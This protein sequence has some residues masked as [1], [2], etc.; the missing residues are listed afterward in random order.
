MKIIK[1]IYP[2]IVLRAVLL[3]LTFILLIPQLA[4]SQSDNNPLIPGDKNFYEIQKAFNDNWN[5]QENKNDMKG[6]KQYKRWE[7]FME[8]RVYPSGILPDPM[9]TYNALNPALPIRPDHNRSNGNWTSM[10]P[11]ISS[12]TG[13]GRINCVV[14]H[15]TDTNIIW[16][17]APSGGLWKSTDGGASWHT[18]TDNL[19]AIGIS[20]LVIHP[21]NPDT[22]YLASSD[23]DAYD[24]Y[25]L[26][27]LKS[28]D[29]GSTWNTTGLDWN[30]VYGRSIRKLIMHPTNPDILFVA[31]NAGIYKTTDG[32]IQW[33]LER[34][35]GFKDIVFKPGNPDVIYAAAYT[36]SSSTGG[37]FYRS[38]DGGD[39][40]S[41]ITGGFTGKANR[42][43]IGVTPD[44]TNYVYILASESPSSNYSNRH[45]FLGFY[46]STNGADSFVEMSTS[47]N[48]LG[49]STNGND[50]R[51]QGWYDLS[52]V[53]SPVNKAEV[54]V[55]GVNIWKTTNE[56]ANWS[57]NAHWYGGGGAPW[58]H[59]DIHDMRFHPLNPYALYIGSD[60]GIFRSLDNGNNYTDISQSLVISQI[61][62][63]GISATDKDLVMVGLQDNGSKLYD[64]NWEN[65]LGG[66]GM[67]CLIDYSNPSYMYGSLYYGDIRRSTNGGN[68]FSGI[69]RNIS[70]DGGWITPFIINPKEPKI[71][72][73]GYGNVWKNE[74][75]GYND[76]IK[77][78]NWGSSKVVAM[79]ISK[80]DTNVLYVAKSSSLYRTTNSGTTWDLL[81]GLPTSSNSITWIEV[82][83]LYPN[84]VY[85]T[86]SGYNASNKVFVSDDFGNTWTNITGGLPNLPANCIVYQANSYGGLYVG[87]DVG[88]YYKDSSL[89]DWIAYNDGLPNVIINDLDIYYD[90]SDDSK[91]RLR[92]ATYG[93]GL[94]E[95]ELYFSP[96]TPPV[97]SF[98]AP[99]TTICKG[100][101]LTFENTSV[102]SGSFKWY[103][104]GGSPATSTEHS[105]RIQ[106]PTT[107]SYDVI[108]V[109]INDF[110]QDS[111][112]KDDFITVDESVECVYVLSADITGEL[113]TTCTGRL[114]DPGENNNYSSN[115][116]TYATISPPG[117]H[118]IIL[119][120]I[121]FETEKDFDLLDI[122]DGPT[123]SS[124]LIGSYSGSALPGQ[125]IVVSSDSA[126]TLRFT[127]DALDNRSGFELTWKCLSANEPPYAY[128]NPT[129]NYSCT[130]EV[131]FKDKSL[132]S[133]NSWMWYF[134]DGETSTDQNPVHSYNETGLYT[135]SLVVSNSNGSDSFSFKSIYVEIPDAPDAKTVSR[136]GAGKVTLTADGDGHIIWLANQN[137]KTPIA[138]GSQFITPN[139]SAS[140]TYYV[141]SLTPGNAVY[142]GPYGNTIG[143]GGYFNGSQGLIFNCQKDILLSSVKVYASGNSVR[144]IVLTDSIGTIVYD[145]NINISNG[146]NRI[147]LNFRIAKG[148]SYTLATSS[149]A[150]YRNNSGVSFP[151]AVDDLVSIVSSTAGDIYYYFFYDW[152]VKEVDV[153]MSPAIAV[154]AQ[155]DNNAPTADFS[156]ADSGLYVNFT[157]LSTDAAH[158]YWDFGD[159]NTS[160]DAAPSYKYVDG[161]NY[162]VK[163]VI[164]NG[165][166]TDS[167]TKTI[168][169]TNSIF[170][171]ADAKF[172]IY[173][174]P[175]NGSFQLDYHGPEVI[176]VSVLDASGHII[177][178]KIMEDGFSSGQIQLNLNT[179]AG[180][181]FVHLLNKKGTIVQK[182]F[183]Q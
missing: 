180:V 137:D 84:I 100:Y 138:T 55:G 21:T 99:K 49:W 90:A 119:E 107:G 150:L 37:K 114:F 171:G 24:T 121:S 41:E 78:T 65:V 57:L 183:I 108:L 98:D 52:I 56:G 125:G 136:C 115:L 18:N 161:G 44:D 10:G 105:P 53:V 112:F 5:S 16:V 92:V 9:A 79:A 38:T 60:G 159:G 179:S 132:N 45:G 118:G 163:L 77:L 75:R 127:T 95:S 147:N 93:R 3:I 81:S 27:V 71:L 42:L 83:P 6:W 32:G 69:K 87:T 36:G 116:N 148:N 129:D 88:V 67:E 140:K 142:G 141:K 155:I 20:D 66:D 143:G 51:G 111:I 94:W 182:V 110:G 169:I 19:P 156:Y 72:Y 133:P 162:T 134:G 149:S 26:G 146:E 89:T 152:E 46:R 63:L 181:Y 151:Y 165:C 97:A 54:Y 11:A 2:N 22:M 130:G 17:G 117:S 113:Y 39:N 14:F 58:V 68:N 172:I 34:N 59:A 7:W 166:G 13:I 167:I 173:P 103:F 64:P 174:N 43:A 62:R 106:Y 120:F 50:L 178:N 70:E 168:N 80:S 153:C 12:G 8:P 154:I 128:F 25:S 33:D 40:F 164:E 74:N 109:A 31:T 139:L 126:I 73:A 102:Y 135:V 158:Y 160:E 29:G 86:F 157:D 35:G 47:P 15:P 76:W 85:V 170:E 176:H 122:F 175:N 96:T 131:N 123:I 82:H 23:G 91:S 1:G 101:A 28:T 4:I 30:I 124:S 48:V 144:N 177:H 145:T 104:P 61:Y